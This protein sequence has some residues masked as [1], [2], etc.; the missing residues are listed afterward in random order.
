MRGANWKPRR[1][2]SAKTWS[3]VMWT[4]QGRDLAEICKQLLDPG[5]GAAVP[6]DLVGPAAALGVRGERQ[7]QLM[8]LAQ[9]RGVSRGG[10]EAGAGEEQVALGRSLGRQAQTV[11]QLQL[12]FQE[13]GFQPLDPA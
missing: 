4:S 5:G 2:H 1:L 11:A 13:V 10:H 7:L 9:A 12:G 3:T 8:P 6:L